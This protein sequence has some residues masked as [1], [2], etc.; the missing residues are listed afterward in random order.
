VIR[1]EAEAA[2]E[3][4]APG[5]H[6]RLLFAARPWAEV[7]WLGL[8]SLL[9]VLLVLPW[10]LSL[11]DG[12][13][14]VMHLIITFFIYGIVAQCWNLIMGVSGIY[15][16]GQLAL[17]AVGAFTTAT[18]SQSFG[19][20]PWLSIWA[21]PIAA[22]IAAVLI[23]LPTLRLRGIYVVL[24]TLAFH[25]LARN[26]ITTGPKIISGG[27]Y[28]LLFVPKLGFDTLLGP[29]YEIVFYYYLALAFSLIASF[30]I[31]RLL[32][33]PVGIAL[34]ALRDSEEYA[35]SR[36]VD[37]FRF[38]LLLFVFS[39]FFTGL[40]GGFTAHYLGAAS[41]SLFDF[42]IMAN[43]LAMIVLGGWGTFWGPIAG[44]AILTFLTE[45]LRTFDAY[46]NL[47]LGL[48]MALIA[49]LAPQGL[50][51]LLARGFH[52]L[53]GVFAEADEGEESAEAEAAAEEAAP[54]E[55]KTPSG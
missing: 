4:A 12:G 39:A 46:R 23:G 24:L 29:E 5:E 27:G 34:T 9:V 20:N 36:G 40:A 19:V 14:Y 17:Y 49:V 28:G 26:F 35:V 3:P 25:E 1:D 43:L 52:A 21:A 18:L 13:N 37:P 44:T 6:S 2:L 50:A 15:S 32:H 16:F 30:A 10:G 53:F 7:N 31:W 11:I 45:F 51:P 54:T 33:S 47:S 48:A 41:T 22:V 38:K 8:F 55:A 42:G